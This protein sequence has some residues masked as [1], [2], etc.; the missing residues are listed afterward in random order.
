M[1]RSF[2]DYTAAAIVARSN[3]MANVRLVVR[4]KKEHYAG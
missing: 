1:K 3:A 2:H 4:F